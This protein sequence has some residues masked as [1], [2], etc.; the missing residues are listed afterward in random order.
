[1]NSALDGP[2]T[3]SVV[4]DTPMEVRRVYR[5]TLRKM[6]D[7]EPAL[8]R[9]LLEAWREGSGTVTPGTPLA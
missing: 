7:Q 9:G 2:R 6:V 5:H 8:E 3:A 1:M 4:P